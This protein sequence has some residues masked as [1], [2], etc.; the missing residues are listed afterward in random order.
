MRAANFILIFFQ[1]SNSKYLQ[2][3]LSPKTHKYNLFNN[4]KNWMIYEK[5]SKSIFSI[6]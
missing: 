6:T 3:Y 4:I 5:Q 1:C 2:Q